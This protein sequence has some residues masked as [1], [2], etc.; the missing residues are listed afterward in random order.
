MKYALSMVWEEVFA[1]TRKTLSDLVLQIS[2]CTKPEGNTERSYFQKYASPVQD[3]RLFIEE[4]RFPE[5]DEQLFLDFWYSD[6]LMGILSFIPSS[7]Y[8]VTTAGTP[9]FFYDEEKSSP[10]T[11]M[12]QEYKLQIFA[13]YF[14]WKFIPDLEARA[15]SNKASKPL[16]RLGY[17]QKIHPGRDIDSVLW[18]L[19]LLR[20]YAGMI[21]ES[22]HHWGITD[23]N[24]LLIRARLDAQMNKQV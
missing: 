16:I 5:K 24:P 19:L 15:F 3:Y 11:I 6:S 12:Y 22:A 21:E 18:R 2:P 13:S 7:D 17:K 23:K 4:L 14:H 1:N 20:N 8:L 10:M 9:A